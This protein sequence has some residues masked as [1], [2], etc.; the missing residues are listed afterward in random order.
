MTYI[1][2]LSPLSDYACLVWVLVLLV[3]LMECADLECMIAVKMR[4]EC[5]C[6]GGGGGGKRE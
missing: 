2:R 6:V 4:R 5:V 3:N 1:V